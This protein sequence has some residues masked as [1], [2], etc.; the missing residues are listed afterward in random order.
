MEMLIY[1]V[2]AIVAIA[3]TGFGVSYTSLQTWKFAKARFDSPQ[4]KF[5]PREA[6]GICLQ[7]CLIYSW[8]MFVYSVGSTLFGSGSKLELVVISII[9]DALLVIRGIAIFACPLKAG[10]A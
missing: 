4:F 5:Q 1:I 3:V 7:A 8:F 10:R 2:G 9:L 6:H